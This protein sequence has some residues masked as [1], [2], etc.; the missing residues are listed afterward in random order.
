M[1]LKTLL[2]QPGPLYFVVFL[3]L[4][5]FI[6]FH[7]PKTP[8]NFLNLLMVSPASWTFQEYAAH[9]Y[10]MH[11]AVKSI[12]T[13]HFNHHK[14]PSDANKIFIP[15]LLT[16]LFASGN[17]APVYFL[18]GKW[19]AL[20]NFASYV[21]CYCSFEYVHWNCHSVAKD[22]LM[23][24]PRLFHLLHHAKRSDEDVQQNYGF[25]SMTW[26]IIFGTCDRH[27]LKS[28]YWPI[29]LLPFPVLPQIIYG[30]FENSVVSP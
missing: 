26:D 7:M 28:A 20:V 11:G 13:A 1:A 19:A 14:S 4:A 23:A 9:R 17:A 3:S 6:T 21:F 24:A 16:L 12:R 30:L 5:T 25:T 8:A 18:F 10:L 2:V 27:T 15:I 29:L 22:R